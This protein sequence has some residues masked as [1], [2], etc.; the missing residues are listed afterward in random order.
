MARQLPE[1]VTV[2]A[3][4]PGSSRN[5]QVARHANFFMKKIMMPMKK[6]MPKFLGMAAPTSV[7]A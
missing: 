4:S 6:A 3:V 5:A 1:G 7:A 2:N